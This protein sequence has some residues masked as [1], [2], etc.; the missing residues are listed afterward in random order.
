MAQTLNT[1]TSS[2]GLL[3][4]DNITTGDIG[5][6]LSQT[7]GSIQIGTLATRSAPITI[8]GDVSTGSVVI[9]SGTGG[10]QLDTN[11]AINV[12][13]PSY[14]FGPKGIVQQL[15]SQTTPVVINTPLGKIITVTLSIQNNNIIRFTV[16]NSTVVPSNI[17]FVTIDAYAGSSILSLAVDNIQT[18]S[19]DIELENGGGGTLNAPCTIGYMIV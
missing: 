4:G 18:G 13:A 5:A 1:A 16:N 8:G 14:I 17:I 11:A 3:L 19:F 9:Q 7:S 6:G 2:T 12:S 10:I 15:T